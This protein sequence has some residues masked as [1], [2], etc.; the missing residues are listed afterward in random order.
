[1]IYLWAVYV[2][3]VTFLCMSTNDLLFSVVLGMWLLIILWPL[4]IPIMFVCEFIK[5]IM[6]K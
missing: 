2:A 3:I 4:A 6:R 1:M 5:G